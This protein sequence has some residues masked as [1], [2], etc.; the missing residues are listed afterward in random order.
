MEYIGIIAV[1]CLI[2]MG[3]GYLL[4]KWY[5]NHW[6]DKQDPPSK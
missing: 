5:L 2:S 6:T 1:F 4:G 3:I